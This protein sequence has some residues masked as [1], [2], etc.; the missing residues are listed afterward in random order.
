M[1]PVAFDFLAVVSDF[2]KSVVIIALSV[3]LS[4]VYEPDSFKPVAMVEGEKV[5]HYHLD[6]LGTPQELSDNE[7]NIVWQ[8]RY[9]EKLRGHPDCFFLC[10]KFSKSCG[11][12]RYCL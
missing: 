11:S 4:G 12:V 1:V 7:G 6:H 8:A 10:C 3:S 2:L 5:Y 9:K